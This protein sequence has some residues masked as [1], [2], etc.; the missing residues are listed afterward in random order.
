MIR[1]RRWTEKRL[2]YLA[3]CLSCSHEHHPRGDTVAVN[4][5]AHN[6]AMRHA[7]KYPD[8]NTVVDAEIA[9]YY[10]GVPDTPRRSKK[11]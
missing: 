7:R 10:R 9:T 4:V 6:W 3:H 5:D 11:R 2:A 8:H 1:V